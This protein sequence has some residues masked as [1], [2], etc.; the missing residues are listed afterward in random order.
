VRKDLTPSQRAVQAGH[1]IA[2]YL[3]HSP[4]S[5]WR[6]ETLIYLGVKSLRQ[7]ENVMKKLDFYGVKYII[8]KEPDLDNEITAISSD[9]ENPIFKKL[10]LL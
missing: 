5:T 7:L 1:A 9:E 10:K 8:W 6:N 4:L 2:E 3:V